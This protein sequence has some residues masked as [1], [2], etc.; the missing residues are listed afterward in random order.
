M[1]PSSG[2]TSTSMPQQAGR[3]G[4]PALAAA[5]PLSSASSGAASRDDVGPA[6]QS[7][8]SVYAAAGVTA[9]AGSGPLASPPSGGQGPHRGP[10]SNFTNTLQRHGGGQAKP[11]SPT[12]GKKSAAA[13]A[14]ASAGAPQSPKLGAGLRHDEKTAVI[15][16]LGDSI[17]VTAAALFLPLD[18]TLV[19]VRCRRCQPRQ[20]A[21]QAGV[22]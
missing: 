19:E 22:R 21:S 20:T 16:R 7:Q 14:G 12:F 8:F 13:A 11:L 15:T 3:P 1:S 17:A 18:G 5:G 4:T 10:L 2:R 9:A 6:Q